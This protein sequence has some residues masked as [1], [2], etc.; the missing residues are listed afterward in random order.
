MEKFATTGGAATSF[1]LGC[2]VGVGRWGWLWLCIFF[3]YFF[4]YLFHLL[5][6]NFIYFLL[7]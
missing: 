4:L 3:L 6:Y 7:F 2:T 1:S 5:Y